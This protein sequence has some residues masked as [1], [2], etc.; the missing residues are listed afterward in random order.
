MSFSIEGQGS[1]VLQ[2]SSWHVHCCCGWSV[3]AIDT[4]TVNSDLNKPTLNILIA[5]WV[6]IAHNLVHIVATYGRHPSLAKN[7][8]G[9]HFSAVIIGKQDSDSNFSET[10]RSYTYDFMFVQCARTC[11][12]SLWKSGWAKTRP[13][14]PLATPFLSHELARE[15]LC[16]AL[17]YLQ[18]S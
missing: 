17:V 10:V 13:A 16:A 15:S 8:L 4:S 6:F 5:G 12:L 2:Q 18:N 3:F 9:D 7:L 1:R 14:W 11:T